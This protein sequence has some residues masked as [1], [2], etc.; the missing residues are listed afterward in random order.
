MAQKRIF[1]LLTG[2]IMLLA[3]S[4]SWS[5]EV[6]GRSSTQL[7][8][9][10]DIFTEKKQVE[11]G[12]YLS[13]SITKV[14]PDGKLSFQGYGRITKDIRNGEPL[15]GRLY[16][17]YG[18]YRD[19]Y[20]K[21]DLRFGRQYVSYAAGSALIDGGQIDVKK[22][23][24]I[25][26]SVMGGRNV[27]FNLT[28]EGTHSQEYV[29]GAAAYLTGLKKTDAELSYF[30]K[31]DKDGIARSQIGADVK[32]YILNNTKIYGNTQYDLLSGSF[33]ELLAGAKYFPSTD[34]VFT[35][36]WYQ[37]YPTFDSTSI[38]SVFAVSRYHEGL[39]RADYTINN[40]I[41]TNI[42][43]S[44]QY[45]EAD[46]ATVIEVGCRIRPIEHLSVM[47]N[48]DRR[49]GYGGNLDGVITEVA[50]E[51]SKKL[52]VAGGIHYDVYERDKLTGNETA[53]KYWI[54][55]KYKIQDNMSASVRV[56]DNVNA[57]YESDYSGRM[58]FNYDF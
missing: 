17:L 34:L 13:T 51:A 41:S 31:H 3:S 2:V 37:S 42:G 49:S 24:P 45:Y 10:N 16:Y 19:L 38:Y 25:A 12:E 9:F 1:C 46:D 35:G 11:L 57:R 14:D 21:V 33:S 28:G 54:G 4:N 39:L 56:E 20:D 43:Y 5:A 36:E 58:A 48:Y 30:M 26:F 32:Q 23:G 47:L 27:Y 29:L 50:Y 18:D 6:H 22:V 55:G 52:E 7:T 53:R 8:W 15:G 40:I 44:K